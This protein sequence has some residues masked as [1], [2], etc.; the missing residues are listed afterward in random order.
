MRLNVKLL[1]ILVEHALTQR[2][3]TAPLTE[4]IDIGHAAGVT[5]E[6]TPVASRNPM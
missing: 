2:E 5:E 4:E 3:V 1:R 6:L